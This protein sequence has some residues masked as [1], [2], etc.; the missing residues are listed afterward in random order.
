MM[1]KTHIKNMHLFWRHVQQFCYLRSTL[2]K[3]FSNRHWNVIASKRA[4]S[5]RTEEVTNLKGF[6]CSQTSW[7]KINSFL[8]QSSRLG[9]CAEPFSYLSLCDITIEPI[10]LH[11]S[12]V[13]IKPSSFKSHRNLSCSSKWASLSGWPARLLAR[14]AR[15][16]LEHNFCRLGSA[17]KLWFTTVWYVFDVLN[18]FISLKEWLVSMFHLLIFYQILDIRAEPRKAGSFCFHTTHWPL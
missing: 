2:Y 3:F 17:H 4:G 8:V 11:T 10:S 12:M 5:S 7:I 16:G 14:L 18:D 9:N 1:F 15:F 6:Q 13:S